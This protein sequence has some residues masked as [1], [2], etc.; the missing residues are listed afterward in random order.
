MVMHLL[1]TIELHTAQLPG[2]DQ[3][4]G[5]LCGEWQGTKQKERQKIIFKVQENREEYAL[6]GQG[7]QSLQ[8]IEFY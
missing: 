4:P 3:T 2:A 7:H 6:S 8:L 1:K 5:Y